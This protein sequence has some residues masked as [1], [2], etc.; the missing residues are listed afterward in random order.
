MRNKHQLLLLVESVAIVFCGHLS[1]Q[2]R[3]SLTLILEN[4]EFVV[5]GSI[6]FAVALSV[7]THQFFIYKIKDEEF[8]NTVSKNLFN[9][10]LKEVALD[11]L[12]ISSVIFIIKD[13][14]FSRSFLMIFLFSKIIVVTTLRK[15]LFLNVTNYFIS[16]YKGSSKKLELDP[17]ALED[18]KKY[19]DK[20]R[21]S[22]VSEI[23]IDLNI[24]NHNVGLD[25]L[26]KFIGLMQEMGKITKIKVGSFDKGYELSV[27][28]EKNEYIMVFDVKELP[29]S[30]LFFK[31]FIDLVVGA[32]GCFVSIILYIIFYI[33][34]KLET[35]DSVLFSQTR[36]GINGNR[37]KM[38]K[39]RTMK[40]TTS[41]LNECNEVDGPAFKIENDPRLTKLG[42]ILRKASLDE[43]PQFF[44]VLKG[45][46]TVVGPRPPL[47]K[48]VEK[49]ESGFYK[50]MS[51]KP[52]ITGYWQVHSRKH[53]KS[54][55]QILNDDIYYLNNANILLEIKILLMT[56]RSILKMEGR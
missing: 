45:D 56:F 2:V 49:Y 1:I 26:L 43:F 4:K 53:T 28:R 7:L 46:M 48:E 9:E 23:E 40:K 6:L 35:K 27:N 41:D 44:N 31:S 5:T 37:F 47:P 54:F 34:I 38:Y 36:V 25:K 13:K 24:R 8:D 22:N 19:F 3:K 20:I 17:L 21:N 18:E 32:V 52:G 50:R 29:I 15:V 12:L 42:K 55:K 14:T 39:F 11:A 33:P 30:L 51:V 16:K 10:I